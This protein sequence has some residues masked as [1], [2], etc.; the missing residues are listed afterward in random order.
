MKIAFFSYE[1]P[2]E[3]GGGGIGTYLVQMVSYLPLFGHKPVVFCAT[4]GDIAFWENDYV[5]RLP[6]KNWGEFNEALPKYFELI[7]ND[8]GFDIAEGTDFRAGGITV[9]KQFT[10]LPFVVRAHTANYIVDKFLYQPLAGMAKW[11]FILGAFTKFQM[12]RLPKP[13]RESNY[14]V[15]QEIVQK[16]DALLSPSHSLG[17]MYQQLGW[18]KHYTLSPFFYQASND[19]LTILPKEEQAKQI[20][21]VFYGRLE[22]RKGVL[23][24]AEAIPTILKKHPYVTFYFIGNPANSPKSGVNMKLYL[25]LKLDRF[26]NNVIFKDAFLPQN[27]GAI[28]SLGDIFLFPSRYDSFGLVCCEAMAAGKAVIGSNSGGMAEIIENV[29]SGLLVDAKSHRQ[30]IEKVGQLIENPALR[31]S[32]GTNGRKQI[33]DKYS[34][35]TIV[36]L[37][38]SMY[39]QVINKFKNDTKKQ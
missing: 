7:N 27:I 19:I 8:I 23:E 31:V 21:I 1:Y 16:C 2:P 28:L 15:E 11:R 37:Q 9:L 22:I 4:S 3:T 34:A 33:I 24:I 25:Q 32:M 10:N 12:P 18:R 29:V 20:N 17:K 5:Y 39:Q 38:I 35:S 13:P 30:I 26:K 36:P 6:A 14:A